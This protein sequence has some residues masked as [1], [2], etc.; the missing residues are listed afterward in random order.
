MSRQA[1]PLEANGESSERFLFVGADRNPLYGKAVR[2]NRYAR[3][4]SPTGAA[5]L[6][7]VYK[8]TFVN[9]GDPL[10]GAVATQQGR[11]ASRAYAMRGSQTAS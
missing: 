6:R 5:D 4:H 9:L 1:E 11:T 2:E 8:S 3:F 7:H 10:N